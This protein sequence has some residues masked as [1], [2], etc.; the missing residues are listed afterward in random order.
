MLS[1]VWVLVAVILCYDLAFSDSLPSMMTSTWAP[2]V[3]LLNEMSVV[4][5]CSTTTVVWLVGIQ[6]NRAYENFSSMVPALLLRSVC[7]CVSAAVLA[8]VY[9]T[10]VPVSS[11][12][13]AASILCFFLLCSFLLFPAKQEEPKTE[14][15]ASAAPQCNEQAGVWEVW[16]A[17]VDFCIL[18]CIIVLAV[19]KFIALQVPHL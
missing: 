7:G 15:A 12:P 19:T 14:T 4:A 17:I 3:H 13:R 2:Q 8:D 11:L 5:R 16:D 6:M 10:H 1:N 18:E 9:W